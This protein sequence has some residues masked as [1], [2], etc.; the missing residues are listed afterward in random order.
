MFYLPCGMNIPKYQYSSRVSNCQREMLIA[1]M[2]LISSFLIGSRWSWWWDRETC[3]E[4]S[5]QLMW[6][7][8]PM[9]LF[10]SAPNLPYPSTFHAG[11]FQKVEALGNQACSL[12]GQRLKPSPSHLGTK[13]GSLV[14]MD[15]FPKCDQYQFWHIFGC[16]KEFFT[17]PKYIPWDT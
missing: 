13:K 3:C 9:S 17:T 5:Q 10:N 8:L 1:K 2:I 11:I 7:V 12:S 4:K 14:F 6:R 16:W 15:F